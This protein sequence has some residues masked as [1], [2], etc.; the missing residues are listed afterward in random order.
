MKLIGNYLSPFTRRVAISLAAYEIPFEL[1]LL[2][3]FKNPEPVRKHNPI[4][5]IPTLVLDDGEALFES[6][7]ILDALDQMV[8]P[9]RALIPP[10]GEARRRVLK[11][12]AVG[13]A[14]MEKAQWA[15][16]EGRFHPP[17]KVH[18]PWIDHNERQALE[19]LDYLD[20]L[21]GSAAS[22]SWIAGTENMS[23]ADITSAV[24]YSFVA[25]VRPKLNV[26]DRVGSLARYTARCEALEIFQV[27]PVPNEL[28]S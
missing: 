17:E 25:A 14:T 26:G 1:E 28:P 10:D 24:A 22:D 5:R 9:E 27:A 4:V 8:G 20:G 21:V 15:F 3:P 11:V 7:M 18:Q 2:T 6:H 12:I 13:T 23:Q 16:Y 19:G